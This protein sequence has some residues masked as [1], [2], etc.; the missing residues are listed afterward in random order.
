VCAV[1][2][3]TD[4]SLSQDTLKTHAAVQEKGNLPIIPVLDNV[5]R[6]IA[7]DPILKDTVSLAVGADICIRSQK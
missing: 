6:F 5:S 4:V 2:D 3:E 7:N 1:G